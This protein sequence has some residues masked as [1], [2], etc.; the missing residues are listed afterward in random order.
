MLPSDTVD[1][2]WVF[3]C[4]S[5]GG[6]TKRLKDVSRH[7]DPGVVRRRKQCKGCGLKFRTIETVVERDSREMVQETKLRLPNK[8]F[9]VQAFHCKW[10][11]RLP[12]WQ[13]LAT[14][15]CCNNMKQAWANDLVRFGNDWYALL[16]RVPKIYIFDFE[17]EE[18]W[19]EPVRL[20]SQPIQFCPWCG[21]GVIV[22]K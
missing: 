19:P 20:P 22:E 8:T 9:S 7:R 16:Q 6:R 15:F 11:K 2:R 14:V 5:C 4:P 18:G 3:K 13:C 1:T 12:S 21:A 10:D 17:W